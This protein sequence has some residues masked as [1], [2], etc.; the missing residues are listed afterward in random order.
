MRPYRRAHAFDCPP[1]P[2]RLRSRPRLAPERHGGRERGGD[3]RV[4]HRVSRRRGAAGGLPGVGGLERAVEPHGDPL[5][6]RRPGVRRRAGRAHQGLRQRRRPDGDDLRRPARER[7]L[8]LGPRA[9]GH[10]ARP[11]VHERAPVHLRP[12]HLRRPHR[13]AAADLGRRLPDPARRQRRRLRRQRAALA[14]QRAGRDGAHQRLVPAVPEPLRRRARLRRGRRALRLGGR[15]REL[16]LRRLRPGRQ[17]GQPLRRSGRRESHAAHGRGRRAAQSG[18]PHDRRPDEPGRHD[19]PHQ[20]GHG[21]R[22]AGQ[23]ERRQR[24]RERP[25]DRRARPAQPL[26]LHLPPGHQ[27][28]VPG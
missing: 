7:A 13:P 3:E 27:R 9:A 26:P 19:H 23:P 1:R 14:A 16:Q 17:S 24:R 28:P 4:Q 10:G 25:P 22:A 21:R 20:P 8:V 6:R 2:L 15:R 12:L 5:R 18:H 11:A